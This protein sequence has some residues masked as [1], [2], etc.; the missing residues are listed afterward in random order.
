MINAMAVRLAFS[1][2]KGICEAKS[3]VYAFAADPDP[4]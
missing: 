1:V 2:F 3:G 4:F